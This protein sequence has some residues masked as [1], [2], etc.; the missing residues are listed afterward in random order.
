[1]TNCII[2]QKEQTDILKAYRKMRESQS[3]DRPFFLLVQYVPIGK[4]GGRVVCR[5]VLS[6]FRNG[7]N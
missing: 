2:T 5:P 4:S 3:N 1:M 6:P 7:D